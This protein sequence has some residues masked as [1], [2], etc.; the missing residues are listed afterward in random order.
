M[1]PVTVVDWTTVHVPGSDEIILLYEKLLIRDIIM[2]FVFVVVFSVCH[3]QY[4]I[5]LVTD[6]VVC[7]IACKSCT[8]VMNIMV[9]RSHKCFN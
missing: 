2:H 6:S 9:K 1:Y 7:L 3:V 5:Y 4:Y 8:R